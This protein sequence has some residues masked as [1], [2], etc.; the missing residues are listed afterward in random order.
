MNDLNQRFQDFK[1]KI[2]PSFDF[3]TRYLCI[4]NT[5]VYLLFLSSLTDSKLLSYLV[6]SV[7]ITASHDVELTVYPAAV[8]KTA[9]EN[10]AI[11]A[12]LSGQCVLLC[13]N[14]DAYYIIETRQYPSRTTAE[15]EVERSVRGSH[16]G[17]VENFLLNVG[18][19]R[20][21]V[22][23]SKLK[24]ILRQGG[25]KTHCD[26]AYM[27]IE[28][29]VDVDVL[30]DFTSRL[31]LL[32][33][34]E[35]LNERNLVE[36]LYGKTL[37]PYPHVRYSERPD[38]CAT[39]LLQGYLLV[40]VD[41]SPSIII[42]PTTFFEQI[43]QVEEYTQTTLV[44]FF[45]R[46][47]RIIGILFS[48]Y[49]LPLWVAL[50]MDQNPTML[51]IPIQEVRLFAFAIQVLLADI[52]VE[53]IRQ[54]LIHTP[55]ILSSIMSFIAVFLLGD[56]AISLGAYSEEILIMVAACN[57]GNLLTPS[58]ELSMANKVFRIMSTM[59]TLVLGSPGF[60]ISVVIHISILL[61]TKTIKYPYLYPF[62]P[63]SYKECKRLLFGT[64]IHLSKHK[65]SP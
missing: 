24:C 27:Y 62:I 48:L 64:L 35:I 25:K 15:P 28:D 61:S 49:L 29:L 17:F 21:R 11:I 16:D 20:R 52:A 5:H 39:H 63:F 38:V 31:S 47:I 37:N 33:D 26:I 34:A 7:V 40:F 10:K 57:I 9:D 12:I 65:K 36:E 59:I 14:S 2:A 46:I 8:E 3:A 4:Q 50:M 23:D 1:E 55:S 30:D 13:E 54:S 42:L 53:W 43:K 51:K 45:T 32:D 6:E 56:M 22:R 41:N 58:Y 44:A 19:V 18:L 60:C